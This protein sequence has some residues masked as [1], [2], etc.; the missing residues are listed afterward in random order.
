MIGA[1]GSELT[2]FSCPGG[3]GEGK[4]VLVIGV[5]RDDALVGRHDAA[6]SGKDLGGDRLAI[7]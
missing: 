6:Q 2:E 4:R 7:G 3:A 1:A 5:M